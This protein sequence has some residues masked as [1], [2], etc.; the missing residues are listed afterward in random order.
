VL[1]TP[2]QQIRSQAFC[3]F[4]A[5]TTKA[6]ACSESCRGENSCAEFLSGLAERGGILN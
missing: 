2:I 5:F 1:I 3:G 4:D 6:F